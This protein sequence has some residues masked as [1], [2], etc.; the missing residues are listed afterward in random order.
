MVKVY[1]K[2]KV[3]RIT[4]VDLGWHKRWL[5]SKWAK[6]IIS[7]RNSSGEVLLRRPVK[8]VNIT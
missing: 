2:V 1:K 3:P 8:K 4:I 7:P 5:Q 6:E